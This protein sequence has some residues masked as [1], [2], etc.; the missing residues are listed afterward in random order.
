M[1]FRQGK[2]RCWVGYFPGVLK[3]RIGV[4]MDDMG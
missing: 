2:V 1:T 4:I 3:R